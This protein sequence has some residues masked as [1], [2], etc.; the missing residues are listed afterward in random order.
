MRYFQEPAD[1]IDVPR[2]EAFNAWAVE[3]IAVVVPQKVEYRKYLS[4]DA[5]AKYTGRDNTNGFAEPELFRSIRFARTRT[6][7]LCTSIQR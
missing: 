3:R 1:T 6:T 4:R 5:M 2:Q 7:R